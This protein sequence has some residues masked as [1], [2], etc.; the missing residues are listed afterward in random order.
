MFTNIIRFDKTIKTPC[1][2]R[3]ALSCLKTPR[4]GL[5]LFTAGGR[6]ITT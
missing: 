1:L 3:G 6:K 2:V 4:A 5:Y